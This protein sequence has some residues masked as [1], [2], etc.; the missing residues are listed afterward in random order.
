MINAN[1]IRIVM[2]GAVGATLV[3]CL[4]APNASVDTSNDGR[5]DAICID[6]VQ[7]WVRNY[8]TN[9]QAM[10][11]RIDSATGL[12][13]NCEGVLIEPKTVKP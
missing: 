13:V 7:Y 3:G 10:A 5:T 2:I 4:E 8:A 1:V 11:P 6:G 9:L 12:Y